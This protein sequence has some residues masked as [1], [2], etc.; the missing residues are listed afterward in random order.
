VHSVTRLAGSRGEI[1]EMQA[2]PGSRLV[3]GPLK[4][5]NFPRNAIV[6]AILRD[7]IMQ[8]PSGETR[9]APGERVLVYALPEAIKRIEKLFSGSSRSAATG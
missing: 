2:Q 4:D 7:G 6:G 8:I 1:L 9:V 5:L 3:S